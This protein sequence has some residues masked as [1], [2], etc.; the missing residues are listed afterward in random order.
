MRERRKHKRFSPAYAIDWRDAEKD[1]NLEL[2]DISKGGV[3]IT[4]SKKPLPGQIL[5]IK[6]FLRKR[7]FILE[8]KAVYVAPCGEGLFRIG[9]EFTSR[10]EEFLESFEREIEEINTICREKI[11]HDKPPVSFYEASKEYL[12]PIA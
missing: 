9:A 11:L 7:M 12:A 6:V 2:I 1:P 8:A 4:S 10:P 5:T 3:A